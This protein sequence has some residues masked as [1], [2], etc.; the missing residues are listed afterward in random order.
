MVNS[1][2]GRKKPEN[3]EVLEKLKSVA[4]ETEEI[5][6]SQKRKFDEIAEKLQS[7]EKSIAK[8]PKLDE[9]SK[10]SKKFVLKHVFENVSNLKEGRNVHSKKEEHLNM[11]WYMRIKRFENHLQFHAYCDPIAPVADKWSIKTNLEFRIRGA[12]EINK[13]YPTKW[14]FEENR[15]CGYKHFLK[16]EDVKNYDKLTAIVK[17]E[18][19]E[20][21]G[22]ENKKSLLFD[23]S[24]KDV[25]DVILL[26]HDTKF[27]VSKMYLAAQSAFFKTLFLGNFSESNKSEIPLH[28]IEPE[29]FQC[30]L[31]FI[32]A[33]SPISDSN[34]ERILLVAD[35]YDAPT[36]IRRCE[37][38]LLNESKKEF[39]KKLQMSTQYRLEELKNQCL[40]KINNIDNVREF[41]P[42]DLSN[43]DPSTAIVI[44]QR[45]ASSQ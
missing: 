26:V 4:A 38:F 37:N 19:L 43:L 42:G 2:K 27:Y 41:L 32:Y 35:M 10:S 39:K 7:M 22:F 45:C 13:I 6:N 5:K 33:E 9:K 36:A 25:S 20:R 12:D 14:C 23:E 28:G 11:E 3:D 29:N 15:G 18:I 16:W 24:Q 31:E 44:L 40:S 1:K 34:V 17:V 30:F 8:I 21:T